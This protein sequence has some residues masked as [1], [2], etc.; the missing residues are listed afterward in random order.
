LPGKALSGNEIKKL[1]ATP[2]VKAATAIENRNKWPGEDNLKILAKAVK[3]RKPFAMLIEHGGFRR[4]SIRYTKHYGGAVYIKPDSKVIA[5]GEGS[6]S[7]IQNL[8][9]FAPCGYFSLRRLD[10]ALAGAEDE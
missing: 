1:M 8:S 6:S 7:F 2:S 10:N 5:D 9:E 4:Y 3:D